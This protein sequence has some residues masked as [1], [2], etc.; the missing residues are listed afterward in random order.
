V[1]LFQNSV[2]AALAGS[3]LLLCSRPA[4]ALDKQ[5]SAH[6]GSIAG[7]E[8]GFAVN[9]SVLAGAAI[10]NPSYTARPDNTGRALLRVAPHFDL[11]LIGRRLSIPIDFNFFSD[12]LRPGARKLL[13]S[14]FDVI[15]GVTST[16]SLSKSHAVEFGTRFERDMPVDRSNYTQSYLDARLRLLGS[17]AAAWPA[18]GEALH[19]GDVTE[20]LTLGWF[21]WNPSYAAR[22]D[23][24]GKALLRYGANLGVSAFHHRVGAGVDAVCFSDRD[25]SALGV[26]ELDLTP[27][28][29]V[30]PGP[31]EVHLAYERDMPID[32][33]GFVQQLVLTYLSTSFELWPG[34]PHLAAD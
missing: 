23:N 16:W 2:S 4:A 29:V 11:D 1:T 18:L 7:A 28:L 6:G 8:S 5:G 33:G 9:G 19:D 27:E 15:G 17:L 32:R 31:V 20:S 12:R 34:G 30:R 14:E 3:F 13:P 10:Y 21:V 25:R 26:S 22:P 24:T